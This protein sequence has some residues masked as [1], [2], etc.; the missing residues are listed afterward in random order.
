MKLKEAIYKLQS[1][2]MFNEIDKLMQCDYETFNKRW[3]FFIYPYALFQ[4]NRERYDRQANIYLP[5][6]WQK[7]LPEIRQE[8]IFDYGIF[9]PVKAIIYVRLNP[10]SRKKALVEHGIY[11]DFKNYR[12][13]V[14]W[15]YQNN[16]QRF[17]LPLNFDLDNPIPGL[18]S[19]LKPLFYETGL[20][21]QVQHHY[22]CNKKDT[23]FY[24]KRLVKW[25]NELNEDLIYKKILR[26][27]NIESYLD[28]DTTIKFV[29]Q[30]GKLDKPT[31]VEKLDLSSL[32]YFDGDIE[33]IEEELDNLIE[34]GVIYV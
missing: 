5:E 12:S 31:K 26:R 23:I 24:Y 15:N 20:I 30:T 25:S 14:L 9:G 4:P 22:N 3:N 27:F 34:P 6:Q 28:L 8:I 19:L 7:Y 1:H 33:E 17:E 11:F 29:N 21:A 18:K 16:N 13:K 32:W 2:P 10:Y